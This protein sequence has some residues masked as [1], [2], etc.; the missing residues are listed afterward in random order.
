MR[1]WQDFKYVFNVFTARE[2][3]TDFTLKT[4]SKSRGDL[5]IFLELFYKS[6]WQVKGELLDLR[7]LLAI[8]Q[9]IFKMMKN[10]FYFTLKA[11]L[12]LKA[13]KVLPCFLCNVEKIK[14]F[15][16]VMTPKPG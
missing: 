2:R 5:G 1:I 12:V 3:N 6:C 4:P 11:L 7:Q 10:A 15:S 13:F 9:T 8:D 14:L 16:K